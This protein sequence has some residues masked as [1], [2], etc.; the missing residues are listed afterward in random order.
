MREKN[1]EVVWYC[2]LNNSFKHHNTFS[3]T[4]IFITFKQWYYKS[5]TKWV[6]NFS[7]FGWN[8]K[9]KKKKIE[10]IKFSI[11]RLWTHNFFLPNCGKKREKMV[12]RKKVQ[13]YPY[14]F[15]IILLIIKYNSTL[16]FIIPLFCNFYHT[17]RIKKYKYYIFSQHFPSSK[18]HF[19]ILHPNRA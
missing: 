15:I 14:F 7:L 18:F 19:P 10:W 16:L 9:G 6:H 4:C 5:L 3:P 17:H 1:I 12:L 8:E 2:C 11:W 13:N